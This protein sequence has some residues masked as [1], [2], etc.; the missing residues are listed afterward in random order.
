MFLKNLLNSNSVR[1]PVFPE[2]KKKDDKV[3]VKNTVTF[4]YNITYIVNEGLFFFVF[5][6]YIEI[7]NN[8]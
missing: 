3:F 4:W 8:S 1:F 6:L 7:M 5:L 2:F